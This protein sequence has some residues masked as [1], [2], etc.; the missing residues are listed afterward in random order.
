MV[1]YSIVTVLLLTLILNVTLLFCY[2][3]S[4]ERTNYWV[5]NITNKYLV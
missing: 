2:S 5:I 4:A 1:V 3:V